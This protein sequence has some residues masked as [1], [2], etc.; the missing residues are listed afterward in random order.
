MP[1]KTPISCRFN[2]REG[3]ALPTVIMIAMV[4]S[5]ITLQIV[6]S[7]RRQTAV[8]QELLHRNRAVLKAYSGYNE[9][10][11]RLLTNP[12]T[13]TGLKFKRR[14]E[15]ENWNFYG[16]P[17]A[18]DRDT[19]VKIRDCASLLSPL[20]QAPALK[21]LLIH[22][23]VAPGVGNAFLDT[24][25]DWQDRND[26]KRLNGAESYDYRMEHY[27][28]GPRNF[29]IQVPRE[30][31]LLKGFDDAMY[32]KI[33]DEI[34]YWNPQR[35]N[36]LLMSRRLLRALLGDDQLADRIC[37]R[38]RENKLTPG[39]FTRMTGI[40]DGENLLFTP[41][42]WIKVEITAKVGQSVDRIEAVLVKRQRIDRPFLV[43]EWKR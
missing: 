33:K 4:I 23:G 28:Y 6:L 7:V 19:T 35:L 43:L 10:V 41:S 36:Y 21:K 1:S 18:L 22:S 11:Y 40:R 24:L 2:N 37:K 25:A 20:S 12:F 31:C 15:E 13:A 5:V 9:V 3:F 34:T 17:I 30:I 42:G 38:R 8:V 39:E 14:G 16:E 26:L 29:F 27:G 32:G